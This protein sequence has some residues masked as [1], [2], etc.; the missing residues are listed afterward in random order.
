MR[1]ALLHAR[2][3]RMTCFTIVSHSFE[4]INRRSLAVNKVVRNRFEGLCR[5]LAETDGLWT[6]DFTQ[7][8]PVR[9][10]RRSEMPRPVPASAWTVGLRYAEQAVSNSLYGAI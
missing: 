7:S 9:V 4:L 8:P 10:F 5:F 2:D 6:A 3:G 1:A